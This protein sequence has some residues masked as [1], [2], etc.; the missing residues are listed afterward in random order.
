MEIF[1][2]A[3]SLHVERG[4]IKMLRFTQGGR[5]PRARKT[6]AVELKNMANIPFR[7]KSHRVAVVARFSTSNGRNA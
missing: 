1:C 5:G 3:F 7:K 2:P 6:L 4:E